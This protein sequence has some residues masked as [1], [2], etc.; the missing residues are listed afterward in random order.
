MPPAQHQTV[1]DT[2]GLARS[3]KLGRP[4][5]DDPSSSFEPEETFGSGD[6]VI[7]RWRYSWAD[8]H[9]RGIDLFK[10]S[11]DRI[12]EKFSYVKG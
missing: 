10:V 11:H 5:F 8:G 4:S 6:R 12:T 7:Q 1:L 2:L 3:A 9:V